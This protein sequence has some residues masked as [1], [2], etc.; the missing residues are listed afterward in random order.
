MTDF[1]TAIQLA[2]DL[3]EAYGNRGLLRYQLGNSQ[4]AIADLQR[5][6]DLFQSGG[7][8]QSYQQTLE[9][10]QQVQ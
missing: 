8:R 4:M 1:D 9:F 5:A 7:D 10:I 2:P 6:A 3:A